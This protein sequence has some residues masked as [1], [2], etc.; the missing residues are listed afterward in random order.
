MNKIE[1]KELR[2]GNLVIT[3]NKDIL[4]VLS[5]CFDRNKGYLING[6][7]ESLFKPI[8]ITPEILEK[9]GFK[10]SEEPY[11]SNIFNIYFKTRCFA[12][13]SD[14]LLARTKLFGV[15][16]C[17][18]NKMGMIHTLSHIKYVH[19]LQNLFYSLTQTELKI[20]L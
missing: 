5:I 6:Y 9:V 2:I 18:Q 12:I 4:T 16:F 11:S 20:N 19:Q 10:R 17:E 14:F 3:G 8:E 1:A 7:E 13:A 15:S